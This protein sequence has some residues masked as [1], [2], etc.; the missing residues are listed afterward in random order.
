MGWRAWFQAKSIGGSEAIGGREGVAGRDSQHF[1]GVIVQPG[2]SLVMG[3]LREGVAVCGD[4]E[5]VLRE[6]VEVRIS[7][8]LI[9][10]RQ[11]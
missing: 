11:T 10:L 6:L 4:V 3:A 1:G 2:L 5:T 7:W 9:M 8:L